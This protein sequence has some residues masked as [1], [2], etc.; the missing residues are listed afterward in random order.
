MI[1]G[2][3]LSHLISVQLPLGQEG[4]RLSSLCGHG[5]ISQWFGNVIPTKLDIEAQL[6]FLVDEHIN[7]LGGEMNSDAKGRGHESSV[8]GTLL[9]FTLCVSSSGWS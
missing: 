1:R 7:V 2:L 4:W 5:T 9:E 8:F 3:T 6:R